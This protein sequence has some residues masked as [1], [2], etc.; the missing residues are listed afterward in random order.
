MNGKSKH[1]GHIDRY[2]KYSKP[3]R[4]RRERY[5]CLVFKGLRTNCCTLYLFTERDTDQPF[6]SSSSGKSVSD[7]GLAPLFC[8]TIS[9]SSSS[10]SSSKTIPA[11]P[12]LFSFSPI[13][14]QFIIFFSPGDKSDRRGF[15]YLNSGLL[16]TTFNPP[17]FFPI[18]SKSREKWGRKSCK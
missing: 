18:I 9:S 4:K 1:R 7:N 10:L 16:F 12:L 14:W 8:K 17:K 13:L 5:F 3:S 2:N 11:L 15:F 6:F